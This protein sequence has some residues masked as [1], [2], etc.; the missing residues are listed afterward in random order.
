[1]TR[2]KTRYLD[3]LEHGRC[4]RCHCEDKP[5]E[6]GSV[7]CAIC[8]AKLAASQ[9]KYNAKHKYRKKDNPWGHT[10]AAR[11]KQKP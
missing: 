9:K 5:L 4:T 2:S 7:R 6:D 3:D 8:N 11:F 10:L 1:M